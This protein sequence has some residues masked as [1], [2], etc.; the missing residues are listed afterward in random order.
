MLDLKNG[1][2]ISLAAAAKLLPPGRNGRPVSISCIFRWI[3]DG[4][5]SPDGKTRVR[6]EAARMGGR[7]LTSVPALERF[8]MAQTPR[9]DDAPQIR[10]ASK[11]QSESERAARELKAAGI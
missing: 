7:W 10:A 9:F 2:T 3:V 1:S 6:L 11:R 4:V 8:A 5:L